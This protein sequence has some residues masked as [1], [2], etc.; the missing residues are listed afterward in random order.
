M[1]NS[2]NVVGVK[3]KAALFLSIKNDGWR[4]S[5]HNEF[6]RKDQGILKGEVSLYH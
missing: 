4:A 5:S 3:V 1:F 2:E 6:E